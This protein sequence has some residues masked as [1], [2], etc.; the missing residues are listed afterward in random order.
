M[1]Q[2]V[3][4]QILINHSHDRA[5]V[6]QQHL[7]T[8]KVSAL[9]CQAYIV[10]V[11]TDFLWTAWSTVIVFCWKVVW[12]TDIMRSLPCCV[13]VTKCLPDTNPNPSPNQIVVNEVL[14]LQLAICPPKALPSPV[15]PCTSVSWETVVSSKF[16]GWSPTPGRAF[17]FHGLSTHPLLHYLK[18]CTNQCKWT[19]II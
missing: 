16:V 7:L 1:F 9:C 12:Y 14:I 2:D 4:L 19:P 6:H 13:D 11:C 8:R 17:L 10:A 15:W 5:R 18:E 3:L